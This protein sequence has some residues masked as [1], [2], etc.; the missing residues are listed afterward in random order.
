MLLRRKLFLNLAPK[1]KIGT[2]QIEDISVELFVRKNIKIVITYVNL[3]DT[4]K[5]KK[6]FKSV[7][8]LAFEKIVMAFSMFVENFSVNF[9]SFVVLIN[10]HFNQLLHHNETYIKGYYGLNTK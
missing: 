3:L 6:I 8:K 10:C 5:V 4:I 7:F 9:Q 1:H 2:R